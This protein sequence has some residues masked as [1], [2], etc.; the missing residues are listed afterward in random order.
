M[1]NFM[2]ERQ[3][4]LSRDALNRTLERVFPSST[5]EGRAIRD[6]YSQNPLL[7]MLLNR[8]FEKHAEL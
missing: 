2:K 8:A 6:L 4:Q 1:R 3:Q 5:P 7:N